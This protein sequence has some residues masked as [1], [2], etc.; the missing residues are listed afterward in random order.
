MLQVIA[1]SL[2]SLNF[3]EKLISTKGDRKL[4]NLSQKTLLLRGIYINSCLEAQINKEFQFL[5]DS[6]NLKD[7]KPHRNSFLLYSVVC[8]L[9]LRHRNVW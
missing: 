4:S 5:I 7:S 8:L 2:S 3:L 9:L 1:L 6:S